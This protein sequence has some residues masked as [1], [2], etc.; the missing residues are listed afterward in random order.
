MFTRRLESNP[1][2]L[3]SVSCMIASLPMNYSHMRHSVCVNRVK[4]EKP[5][6][7]MTSLMEERLSSTQV[8]DSFQK[9]ILLVLLAL[10]SVLSFAGS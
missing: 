3:T 9:A 8:E 6:T 2:K 4:L 5:S 10:L 1:S 7:E